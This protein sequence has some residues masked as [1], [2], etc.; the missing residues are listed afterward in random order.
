MGDHI[1]SLIYKQ[2]LRQGGPK[3]AS[4][5]RADEFAFLEGANSARAT[6]AHC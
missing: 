5:R 2:S 1:A 3:V 4:V 6:L